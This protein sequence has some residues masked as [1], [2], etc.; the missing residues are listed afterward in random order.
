MVD[1]TLSRHNPIV[2]WIAT[3]VLAVVAGFILWLKF[4]A[5]DSNNTNFSTELNT[6]VQIT[7]GLMHSVPLEDIVDGASLADG[8]GALDMP[9]FI[10][11]AEAQQ[12]VTS[13]AVGIAL[14]IN[15]VARFYP[16][17]ALLPHEIVNDT[18]GDQRVLIAYCAQCRTGVVYDPIVRG[19]SVGF[20]VSGKMWNGN[21]LMYDR[22]TGSFWSQALGKAVVG[23]MTGGSLPLVAFD[24]PRFE[25]WENAHPDGRVL[26]VSIINP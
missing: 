2:Y 18:I 13:D 11:I 1:E 19:E 22:L 15:G 16:F 9:Q 17:D 12:T 25:D 23:P 14:D 4:D 3:L 6:N 5:G 10:S 21:L 7:D 26:S 8:I 20:D 24:Q